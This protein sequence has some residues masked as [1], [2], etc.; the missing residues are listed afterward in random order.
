VCIEDCYISNGDDL[1]AVKSGWDGYGERAACPSVNVTIRRLSGTT[2][3]CAGVAIGSEVSG[4]VAR[5]RAED[6]DV[7]GSAYGLR[8]KT[9]PGRGGFIT[10]VS[11]ANVRLTDVRQAI[12]FS[13]DSG[14]RAHSFDDNNSCCGFTLVG[15]VSVRDV[16]GRGIGSPGRFSS[17][18]GSPPFRDLCFVNVSLDAASPSWACSHAAS[19]SSRLVSPPLCSSFLGS[20]PSCS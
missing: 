1:V 19:G 9:A 20:S 7:S 14:D 17:A 10:D 12:V 6:V 18:P 11:F 3:T 13:G 5:V 16:V 2:R 4:G 8:V 15:R